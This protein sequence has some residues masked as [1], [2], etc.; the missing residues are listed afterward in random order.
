MDPSL[1]QENFVPAFKIDC[2]KLEIA[3]MTLKIRSRSNGWHVTIGLV[4]GHH[5][6]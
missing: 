6:P 2:L 3:I 5:L 4:K 1:S